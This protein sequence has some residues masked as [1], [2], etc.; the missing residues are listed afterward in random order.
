MVAAARPESVIVGRK[1]I[2]GNGG[3]VYESGT[4]T[5][6]TG[7]VVQSIDGGQ[8]TELI[9]F[10]DGRRHGLAEV[11]TKFPDRLIT[12]WA[13]KQGLIDGQVQVWSVYGPLLTQTQY[14][15]GVEVGV[16][17]E[18]FGNGQLRLRRFIEDGEQSGMSY[19][20]KGDGSFSHCEDSNGKK[21]RECPGTEHIGS[22]EHA[23]LSGEIFT[24]SQ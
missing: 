6:F 18:W 15:D 16:R 13:Y 17:S 12:R 20:W 8:L 19:H 2:K 3:T 10:I 7:T 5:P 14:A 4:V 9:H 11:Y 24:G 22:A 23:Q 21:G 1:D